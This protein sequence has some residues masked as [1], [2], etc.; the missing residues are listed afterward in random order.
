[1]GT[2]YPEH[3]PSGSLQDPTF[4]PCDSALNRL[5]S[6]LPVGNPQVICLYGNARVFFL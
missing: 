6:R 1:M 3:C 4:P 5:E 2:V